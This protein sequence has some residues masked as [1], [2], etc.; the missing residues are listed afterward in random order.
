MITFNCSSQPRIDKN[1]CS[2]VKSKS[3]KN[4]MESLK[5]AVVRLLNLQNANTTPKEKKVR[6]TREMKI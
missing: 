6:T 4:P 5:N 1:D 2:F 3:N